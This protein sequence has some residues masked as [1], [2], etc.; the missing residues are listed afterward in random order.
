MNWT[1]AKPSI[2]QEENSLAKLP[3]VRRI[4][5]L[6]VTA[7][8]SLLVGSQ[9]RC[10]NRRPGALGLGLGLL[11]LGRLGLGDSRRVLDG[12]G[13]GGND[14]GCHVGGAWQPVVG[15]ILACRVGKLVTGQRRRR[16][17]YV[18]LRWREVART[19]EAAKN[20]RRRR[21]LEDKY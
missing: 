19:Q 20:D 13:H 11:L 16:S 4:V 14:R 9:S 18:A 2:K 6:V 5:L 3:H 12:L 21:R 1:G 8:G 15:L 10:G 17:C 7:A